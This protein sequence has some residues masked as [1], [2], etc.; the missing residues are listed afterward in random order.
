[1]PRANRESTYAALGS[2]ARYRG[3]QHFVESQGDE[4]V[5][6]FYRRQRRRPVLGNEAFERR[7]RERQRTGPE[8]ARGETKRYYDIDTVVA[9]GCGH[10]DTTEEAIL[11]RGARGG[12]PNV[13]RSVAMRLCQQYTGATLP[14]PGDHFGGI[15]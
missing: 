5:A 9:R 3:Y 13:A 4:Q 12:S 6:D 2:H 11:S 15:H 1:M 7:V 8:T 14:E 10:W